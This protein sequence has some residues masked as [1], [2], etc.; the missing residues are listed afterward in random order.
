MVV[1]PRYEPPMA[2][3][4]DKAL[5]GLHLLIVDDD[6]SVAGMLRRTLTYEGYRVSVALSGPEGLRLA[7]DERPDAVILD[8]ML[9][10]VDGLEVC[11]RL[12]AESE[13]PVLM[14]TARDEIG[15][16]VQGLDSGADDY[17]VKPFA[18]EELLAR[19]RAL[20]RRH[21]PAGHY[22]ILRCGDI[23]LDTARRQGQRG[24]RS[25]DL[26]TTEYELLSLFLQHPEHVLTR[27]LLMERV[28]GYDFAGE[29]N[30]LEVYVR[31][32]RSKLEAGGE[33]R[34]LHTVRGAGYVLRAAP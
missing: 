13:L 15:D 7:R 28:W 11:R 4:E 16:R 33:P 19:L 20:L 30:V 14:L 21:K 22:P 8:V 32:L 6:K 26:T 34:V 23:S 5:A 27:D 31:Y 3:D 1:V 18:T 17:L 9:P 2:G 10:G 25:F 29:S 12:R 24:E